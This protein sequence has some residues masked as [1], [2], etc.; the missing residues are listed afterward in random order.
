MICPRCHQESTPAPLYPSQKGIMA[1]PL[2]CVLGS[3]GNPCAEQLLKSHQVE[4]PAPPP[5]L[6]RDVVRAALRY[7]QAQPDCFAWRNNVG[8]Q[9]WTDATGKER[10]TA[11][12]LKGSA[13]VLALVAPLGRL[14]C[15]EL[16]RP[17]GKGKQSAVQEKFERLVTRV[18]A[19]YVI[20]DNPK[21]PAVR[22]ALEALRGAA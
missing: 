13:D 4:R 9:K 17:D 8:G 18:G 19:V 5:L 11:T 20:E 15:V 6:E 10:Y 7:L 16:K 3:F 14:L 1:L 12:S 22:A 2:W 21:L